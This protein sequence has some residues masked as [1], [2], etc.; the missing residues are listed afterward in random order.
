MFHRF[1]RAGSL[2]SGQGSITSEEF[3]KII[4]YVGIKNII[5]AEEWLNK[6]KRKKLKKSNLC[7]TFDDGLRCQKEIAL[8][9]LNKYK[10][11]AFW[12]IYSSIFE[13]DLIK[14]EVYSYFGSRH[15]KNIDIFFNKF[16]DYCGEKIISKLKEKKFRQYRQKT[17]LASPFYSIND[18]KFRFIRNELL[19]KNQFEKIVDKI[20]KE[21]GASLIKMSKD[22][23]L[24]NL[25][26]KKLD[27]NGHWLGLH[28]Y[29]HPFQLSKLSYEQQLEQYQKNY[30]H[31]S[32]LIGKK[33]VSMSHPLGS[34][35][36]ST[37]KILSQ[38]KIDCGF[39]SN[40]VP[41]QGKKINP[42][43]LEIAREDGQ[44]IIKMLEKTNNKI[45]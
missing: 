27:R 23:W 29:N 19:T 43:N 40:M 11:K 5:S 13:G 1:H 38:L 34:Y 4:N 26:L 45:F 42:T 20:I 10:I 12:F 24:S 30:N 2:P 22:L 31:L 17:I 9:I 33:I 44:N 14:S 36:S 37:L 15:Y 41:P 35:N 32:I 21:K 39:R 16:F 7:I 6:I 3:E 25:E 28:S 8:P 18:L